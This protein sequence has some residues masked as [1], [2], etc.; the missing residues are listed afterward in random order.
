MDFNRV[1]SLEQLS[2]LYSA[3]AA[4]SVAKEITFLNELYQR[5]ILAS[6]FALIASTGPTGLDCSPRGDSPGF[7]R[8][9]DKNTLAIPDRPGNNRLDTLRNILS[10][11][12]VG[13]LFIIPGLNETIR[14]NGRAF[15]TTDSHLLQSFEVNEKSP[16]SAI[17]VDIDQVYFQCARALKRSRLWESSGHVD[18]E[19]LP[20]AGALIK[21]AMA[22][23]DAEAYDGALQN[24]QAKT[25]W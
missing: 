11:P 22:D 12:H 18:P 10:D 19:S 5:F 24:R 16:I 4:A 13:L 20:S 7:V 25:L 17:V 9:L 2:V 21:S 14:V 6:P 8:I 1:S 15:L 23:F 3:P